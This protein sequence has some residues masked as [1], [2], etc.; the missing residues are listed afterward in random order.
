MPRFLKFSSRWRGFTLIELLVVIA[1]IAILI[2]L[3]L[4]AV[5]KIREAAGRA[6]SQNNLHQIGIALHNCHDTHGHLPCTTGCFPVTSNGTDWTQPF[7]PSR[8]GT[9]QYF[10]LPFMEQDSAYRNWE[11]NG[12]DN[13][14]GYPA[15]VSANGNWSNA[16]LP[17]R[18][19]SWWS[20]AVIKTFMAPNDPSLPSDGRH[21]AT[22]ASGQGRGANSYA[23][24]WHVFR[25]GW[26][27]DWQIGGHARI[28]ATIPDGTSNTIA[29]F[30]RYAACG[31]PQLCADW[32]KNSDGNGHQYCAYHI[33]NEDGQ[34]PGPV[35]EGWNPTPGQ[36]VWES[37]AWWIDYPSNTNPQWWD[38]TAPPVYN[39]LPY[40]LGWPFMFVQLPQ[41]APDVINGC[42]PSR[43]QAFNVGGLNVLLMDGHV[44]LVNNNI[45]PLTWAQVIVPDDH[46]VIA[47]EWSQ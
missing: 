13:G 25:G 43:L 20:D 11:I 37:T 3:L 16:H 9:Q 42:D 17:H 15:I 8:F 22:G 1:I 38:H 14:Q 35:S 30:E 10:L 45:A 44:R 33:W 2:G 36:W 4:P 39:G 27:E 18:S 28:P 41:I 24:N 23:A 6:Q 46:G 47:S 31:P 26:C 29:Y 12:A 21:W 5:Q 32:G 40:P 34:T 19:D 7:L